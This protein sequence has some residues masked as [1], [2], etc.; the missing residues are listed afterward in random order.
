MR[1]VH[2]FSLPGAAQVL[3]EGSSP[4]AREGSG[5]E[6]DLKTMPI[7]A[8]LEETVR[9]AEAVDMILIVTVTI[10]RIRFEVLH[11][12]D[13]SIASRCLASRTGGE[14]GAH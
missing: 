8:Y 4:R 6:G 3:R 2:T 5:P 10:V 9:P 11:R 12:A 14:S 1:S 7:R 13:G